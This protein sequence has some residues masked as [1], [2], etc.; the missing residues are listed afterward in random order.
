[1]TTAISRQPRAL[2]LAVL[3][4]GSSVLPRARAL[5]RVVEE[6]YRARRAGF[7]VVAV[8]SA[9]GD[10]TDSL[11]AEAESIGLREERA[12]A[13]WIGAG[14]IRA[15][16]ML[17]AALEEQGQPARL[18]DPAELDLRASGPRL[19]ASATG[20]RAEAL[21]LVTDEGA[22]AVVPGFICRHE[23]GGPALLGRGGSDLSALVIA[24]ATG[25]QRC[26]LLKDT[27][28]LFERDPNL[29]GPRPRAYS[30][31]TFDTARKLDGVLQ[32]AA[33]DFAREWGLPFSVTSLGSTKQSL[34][35]ATADR[36]APTTPT[37]AP[38]TMRV[39][40]AGAGAVGGA[41]ARRLADDDRFELVAVGVRDRSRPR[42]GLDPALLRD[43]LGD[44]IAAE[45][46]VL[47]EVI[48]GIGDAGRLVRRAFDHGIDVVSANKSL[49]FREGPH[50]DWIARRAGCRLLISAAVGGGLPVLETLRALG[51]RKVEAV[52]GCLNGTASFILA[53]LEEG[54]GRDEAL[55]R[56]R[57]RGFAE[58]DPSRDLSGLDAYEKIGIVARLL[59]GDVVAASR[60][61]LEES[62][63]Q[64]AFADRNEGRRRRLIAKVAF[65]PAGLGLRLEVAPSSLPSGDF[66][67]GGAGPE[68]RVCLKLRDGSLRRLAGA[69]AGGPATALSLHADLLDLYRQE[70]GEE[71]GR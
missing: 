24:Q 67:A 21:R 56:A 19:A 47:V 55:K 68:N 22:I 70:R 17:V 1:M 45:P 65:N 61:G 26:L 11:V 4:F 36:F 12:R 43:D 53:E 35:G 44:L 3:K 6:I 60:R 62:E 18:L 9:F 33:V 32:R 39:A 71:T 29:P 50:L 5:P 31:L 66:L 46:D 42:E 25:A 13:A 49:I 20:V 30:E 40:L 15:A 58:A 28:G 34:V 38:K 54:R 27:E 51:A 59:D 69:G 7:G 37:P 63:D 64:R 52:E 57:A 48:G 8:V 41:L 2:P 23:E 16:A 14:E 10:T